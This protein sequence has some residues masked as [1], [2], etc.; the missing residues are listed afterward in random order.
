MPVVP[1]VADTPGR[2]TVVPSLTPDVISVFVVSLNPTST[3]HLLRRPVALL[4]LQHRFC[5]S[6]WTAAF[7]TR[8]TFCRWS[9]MIVTVAFMPGTGF[10]VDAATAP[11]APPLKAHRPPPG[12]DSMVLHPLPACRA[13][14]RGGVAGVA[15]PPGR[16]RPP[17]RLRP[18]CRS[19]RRRAPPRRRDDGARRPRWLRAAWRS[20]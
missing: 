6:R 4:H 7:G 1:V 10:C 17:R 5:P 14:R 20:Q 11:P 9:V 16:W 18:V 2:M 19:R 15:V 3:V 12:R 13:C 8:S